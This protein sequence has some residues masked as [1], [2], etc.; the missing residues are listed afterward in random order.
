VEAFPP[1][2]FAADLSEVGDADP[3]IILPMRT[4]TAN[5][6]TLVVS[7]PCT[8]QAWGEFS[9]ALDSLCQLAGLLGSALERDDLLRSLQAER[10][11]LQSLLDTMPD[12]IYFKDRSSR[13]VRANT[14]QATYFGFRDPAEEIG[15]TDFDFYPHELAQVLYS[16]EQAIMDTRQ[17]LVGALEDHTA[18]GD[19]RRW[20]LSTKVPI[21]RDGQVV[22]LVGISRDV[23]E[24]KRAEE[25]LAHQAAA[26]EDLA[27][28]RSNFVATVSH[29][30][31]SPLT[32]IVGYAELLEAQWARLDDPERL[33]MIHHIAAAANRQMRLVE[34]L[35]LLS[36][37]ELG[38]IAVKPE[39]VALSSLVSRAAEEI[40]TSYEGQGIDLE[41]PD[42]LLVVA[43]P[44][45]ALQILLNL[46]DNAAKYSP[47]GSPIRVQWTREGT[48][49]VVRVR[50]FGIGVSEE[51]RQRL[52]TRFGRVPGSRIRAGRVGTGLGL[53]L[54]RSFAQVMNGEV[55]LE[56]TGPAG[57]TFRL[58]LPLARTPRPTAA[59]VPEDTRT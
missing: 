28:L 55:E 59:K 36:R 26:A 46:I 32:A 1:A 2:E 47:E 4:A 15:K 29:E 51:G 44:D 42:N 6:G 23:T 48:H 33:K 20:V 25:V 30:L 57:S 12:H 40:R 58:K 17:P 37:L 11:L 5:W 18:L 14:A 24:M 56:S 8:S 21:V 19:S 49:A 38:A 52:F 3:V 43:D 31:R 39:P 45:R 41:G 27:R 16:A 54:A 9:E 34:E 53:Y 35:L 10:L 13:V 50:D 7:T 22:G